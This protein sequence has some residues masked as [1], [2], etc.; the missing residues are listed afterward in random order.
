MEKYNLYVTYVNGTKEAIEDHV[1]ESDVELAN[2][3]HAAQN[4]WLQLE[5]RFL[6][7]NNIMKIDL[8]DQRK[9]SYDENDPLVYS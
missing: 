9:Q 5:R 4:S 8:I 2:M 3:L 6:N 7:L 1:V